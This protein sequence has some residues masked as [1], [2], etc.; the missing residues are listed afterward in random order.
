MDTIDTFFVAGLKQGENPDMGFE[1]YSS[2]HIIALAFCAIVI[3]SLCRIFQRFGG[4]GR[5]KMQ[6]ALGV[7]VILCEVVREINLAKDG[8]LTIAY[9]PL[10]LCSFAVF[11]TFFHSLK[12]GQRVGN[13]LY[14]LCLPGALCA[15]LFPDWTAYPIWCLHSIIG[16]LSHT[17]LVSYAF[18]NVVA[19]EI[20]PQLRHLPWSFFMLL[21]LAAPIYVFDVIFELNYMFLMWPLSGTPLQIFADI[22]GDRLF[23]I[24]YIPMIAVAWLALYLPYIAEQIAA[25]IAVRRK[26][27]LP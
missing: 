7:L 14:S 23:I 12:P 8:A 1:L 11:F 22:F 4:K 17:L 19:G 20:R 18:M 27:T 6:L 25:R 5:R 2:E 26:S 16:F 15:L 21:V 24:G 10:H 13:F 3:A 9:L